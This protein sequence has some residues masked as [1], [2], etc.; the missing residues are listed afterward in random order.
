VKLCSLWIVVVG[1]KHKISI[2]KHVLEV[3]HCPLQPAAGYMTD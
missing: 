3:M 2:H 1:H